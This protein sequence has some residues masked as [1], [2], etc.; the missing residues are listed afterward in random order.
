MKKSPIGLAISSLLWGAIPVVASAAPL[1]FTENLG[2][3]PDQVEFMGVGPEA[4]VWLTKDQF[5]VDPNGRDRLE[6]PLIFSFEGSNTRAIEGTEPLGDTSFLVGDDPADW[7]MRANVSGRVT[8]DEVYPGIDV[9]FRSGDSGLEYDVLFDASA[10]VSSFSVRVEGASNLRVTA[11]GSLLMTTADGDVRQPAP[12]TWAVGEEG[13]TTPVPTRFV[14]LDD[15]RFGFAAPTRPEDSELVVDPGFLWSTFLGGNGDDE[16][17]DMV[18]TRSG[19]MVLGYSVS[20]NFPFAPG[21]GWTYGST[22]AK[23][24]ITV[25]WLIAGSLLLRSVIIG[26][27]DHDYPMA[28]DSDGA[29]IAVVG[30]TASSNFPVTTGAY[31]RSHNGGSGDAFALVLDVNMTALTY[32]TFLGSDG[33]EWLEAVALKADG[34]VV[35]AGV[36]SPNSWGTNPFPTTNGALKTTATGSEDGIVVHVAADGKTLLKSTFIGG[37]KSEQI[38]DIALRANGDVVATG[39]ADSGF[40]TTA[41]AYQKLA[42]GD[43]DCF[44][45]DLNKSF[46]ALN[47][48]TYLGGLSSDICRAV[49]LEP[50]GTHDPTGVVVVAGE[51]VSANF[52]VTPN[53]FQP[54]LAQGLIFNFNDAFVSRLDATGGA[55]L[56]STYLGGSSLE[57]L[58]D[59]AVE[60]SGTV[61]VIGPHPSANFP[62]TTYSMSGPPQ[63]WFNGYASRLSRD[64]TK[65]YYST[66]IPA[67]TPY[68]MSLFDG[69]G[70]Y[71][72]VEF[73]GVANGTLTATTG[74]YDTSFNGGFTDGTVGAID[75]QTGGTRTFGTANNP[76]CGLQDMYLSTDAQN[77]L[78]FAEMTI[79]VTNA[80][81]MATGNLWLAWGAD[82]PGT[83]DPGLGIWHFLNVGTVFGNV[84]FVSDAYGTASI[85][86]PTAGVPENTK[87]YAQAVMNNT[88]TCGGAGSSSASNGLEVTLLPVPVFL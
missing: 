40:P 69:A 73:A 77:N 11:D 59:V 71:A 72:A 8:Y 12:K 38:H 5:V 88:A 54:T 39:E 75:M 42:Q 17:I 29:K 37:N 83:Y 23:T 13:E 70:P 67:S 35:A 86:F 46:A 57:Q 47:W 6:Q 56:A 87:F 61:T 36:H 21:P 43:K 34:T 10:D 33:G 27:S 1:Q 28:I 49:A 60:S 80:P 26:G 50:D 68:Q 20:S 32:S 30:Q 3:W 15:Q 85:I 52:P 9:V 18:N 84:P 66:L 19:T 79:M 25:S 4:R 65:L 81:P 53:A 55:L 78:T 64:M 7:K 82:E 58:Y 76:A 24:D 16:A 51:T 74:A 31:D 45:V 44:V 48:S 41:F 22:T 2:Q 14:V 63:F 62:F